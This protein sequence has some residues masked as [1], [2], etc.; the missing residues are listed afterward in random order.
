MKRLLICLPLLAMVPANAQDRTPGGQ[1]LAAGE[2]VKV[3]A[4]VTLG[5]DSPVEMFANCPAGMAL[6]GF[7]LTIAGT[8]SGA[9][10]SN[11]RPVSTFE[12]TCRKI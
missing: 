6:T 7:N 1:S 5:G 4:N 9:C 11:G 10:V 3:P 2:S 8:C 12:I